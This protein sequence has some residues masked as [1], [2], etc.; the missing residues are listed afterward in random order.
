MIFTNSMSIYTRNNYSNILNGYSSI[1]GYYDAIDEASVKIKT[2]LTTDTESL[3][4]E[5][6]EEMESAEMNI[7]SLRSNDAFHEKWKVDLLENM[8]TEYQD[9]V[10]QL[11]ESY[12]SEDALDYRP[13]YNEFVET[14]SL[15]T[16][17][18]SEYYTIMTDS[19]EENR[20]IIDLLQS[21]YLWGSMILLLLM[22]GSFVY[23]N[24]FVRNKV[25]LPIEKI[26]S[27]IGSI[28]KGSYS[29]SKSN[30][31]CEEMDAISDAMIEMTDS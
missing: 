10:D 6:K 9:V 26:L 17:T 28:R 5:Y 1:Q 27:D 13:T 16:S 31:N 18:S 23:F 25:I 21:G 2:Y 24:H 7:A 15:I 20:Q 8:L 4:D 11:L 29:I 14:T 19:M 22:I 3:L 30:F 12:A